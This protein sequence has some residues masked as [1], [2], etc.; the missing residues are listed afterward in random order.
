MKTCVNTPIDPQDPDN[1]L[2]VA[3]K[4]TIRGDAWTYLPFVGTFVKSPKEYRRNLNMTGGKDSC[5]GDSG[6]PLWKWND[7]KQAV[8]TGLVSYGKRCASRDL[9]A[10][11]TRVKKYLNWIKNIVVYFYSSCE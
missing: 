6:G 10:I 9:G 5:S 11:Y 7:Q 3:K 1:Q 2:C 4:E 8:L